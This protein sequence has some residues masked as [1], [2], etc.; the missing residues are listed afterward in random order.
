MSKE[1][2]ICKGFIIPK[3]G[4]NDEPIYALEFT[5][6]KRD[7]LYD[8]YKE[9]LK[10]FI[11]T[12]I[13]INNKQTI[14]DVNDIRYLLDALIFY[15]RSILIIDPIP[16]YIIE[17]IIGGK[18]KGY[19]SSPTA[20]LKCLII[21]EFRSHLDRN[22][23]K[24]EEFENIIYKIN[25][26]E[27][28]KTVYIKQLSK[29][30]DLASKLLED[31]SILDFPA[32]TRPGSNT[33]SLILHMLTVSAIAISI[34]MYRNANVRDED[35]QILRLVALFHDIG[36]I[37][38]WYYHKSES[39][40]FLSE[41]FKD[42]TEGEAKEIIEKAVTLIKEK[43]D[44]E[45]YKIFKSADKIASASDRMPFIV[46]QVLK[47]SQLLDD[48]LKEDIYK[49]FDDW[50]FWKQFTLD[51]KKELTEEF[52]KNVSNIEKIIELLE[53]TNELSNEIFNN[54]IYI[55]RLDFKGIQSF[56]KSNNLKVM[57]G[58]SRLV[59]LA[60]FTILPFILCYRNRIGLYPENILY[61]GGGNITIVIPTNKEK[62]LKDFIDK[63]APWPVRGNIRYAGSYLYKSFIK[64]NK[65]IDDMLA[66]DKLKVCEEGKGIDYNLYELCKSCGNS[67]IVKVSS[68]YYEEEKEMC[69]ECQKKLRE[70][71]SYHFSYKINM[72]KLVN[73]DNDDKDKLLKNI[74]EYI[75]GHKIKEIKSGIQEYKDMA[76]IK[77]DGNLMG[78][79]MTSSISLTD[80]FERSIRIDYS[81]KQA[82]LSFL[83]KLIDKGLA[84]YAKRIIMG[85][86]YIGGDDGLI[87]V[88][89]TISIPFALHMINEYYLNMGKR[90]T[91]S[92]G[93]AIAKPKHPIQ[94]LK[95]GAEYLLDKA[96]DNTR[97]YT[98]DTYRYVNKEEFKGA[99]AFYV[100][101]GGKI[102]KE[103]LKFIFGKLSEEG[104]TIQPY[105][106][107]TNTNSIN[108]L[109]NIISND[110]SDDLKK[111][112]D[113]LLSYL[114]NNEI[115][116]KKDKREEMKNIRNACLKSIQVN[117]GYH[118][119]LKL[120]IVYSI[121]ESH[122]NNLIGNI[123]KN[124]LF[125]EQN[126]YKFA[127]YDL[128]MLLKALGVEYE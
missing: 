114:D 1:E 14:R 61:N 51:Q 116:L 31:P 40:K 36:K 76:L 30:D 48:R 35:I 20:L 18:A 67:A 93:I 88:P 89:S 23:D 82:F 66:C 34:Y 74:L 9:F 15:L 46:S 107:T 39:A 12:Y 123:V 45:L 119:D 2:Y 78:Q 86:Q 90:S 103:S 11:Q 84:E 105:L 56:I 29:L 77:F 98:Y 21:N 22:I 117:V 33:S 42:K 70:G 62:E 124:L 8:K 94:L 121:K 102:S 100:A 125:V 57:N 111:Y 53:Q 19:I 47:D 38:D 49:R 73:N 43:E 80:A 85:L 108:R 28:I 60:I 81:I 87:I 6:D 109:L 44:D 112:I 17:K 72:L 52:C 26:K 118:N 104:L 64:T 71:V 37:K 55:A 3:R 25:G 101:D 54:E 113:L 83:N 5:R 58:A 97:Q 115:A 41:I 27:K 75:A 10:E 96:K 24:I 120:K 92:V 122:D 126:G 4:K 68:N 63:D 99:L 128:Y 95:D 69:K 110:N 16:K 79:L 13:T 50:E 106:V 91:L 7:K 65:E 32:D 59:D 127:L